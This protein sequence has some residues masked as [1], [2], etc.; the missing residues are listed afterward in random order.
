MQVVGILEQEG[1]AEKEIAE[2]NQGKKVV[3]E[4]Q[5]RREAEEILETE[6]L[7]PK[8]RMVQKTI[9]NYLQFLNSINLL[10]ILKVN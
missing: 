1:V 3:E 5:E 9:E 6:P 8:V 2:D 10:L 4:H 7:T